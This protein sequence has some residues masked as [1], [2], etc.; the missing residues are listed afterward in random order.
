MATH[1]NDAILFT[2]LGVLVVLGV[3][4]RLVGPPGS[5]ELIL[6]LLAAI[7][8]VL[9]VRFFRRSQADRATD[10]DRLVVQLDALHQPLEEI[11]PRFP[12]PPM[13]VVG[14]WTATPDLARVLA[15]LIH[16][17]HP[18]VV[19]ELGSGVSSLVCGY[20]VER[21][22]AGHVYSLDHDRQF[23]QQT[24]DT[25]VQHQLQKIVDVIDGP[26]VTHQ[27]N[28]KSWR[29]YDLTGLKDVRSI[30]LLIVDGP[31]VTVGHLARY[32]ALPLLAERMSDRAMIVLDDGIRDDER[33]IVRQWLEL[34]P[35]YQSEY[36]HT[37]KG[38]FILRRVRS[39][40]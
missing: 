24:R 16:Q 30:D 36:L 8:S 31:P 21:N 32:P 5:Y 9:A 1:R 4:L 10:F 25:L 26:L 18:Q 34:F 14:A 3:L 15:R 17:Q 7:P 19:V 22:G 29:W 38:T 6:L 12:L 33:Q 27:L 39:V 37:E 35:D 28:G 2:G 40:R 13:R 11:A 20:C 23:A